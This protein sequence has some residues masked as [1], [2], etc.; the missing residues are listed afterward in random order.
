[1]TTTTPADAVLRAYA[2]AGQDHVFRFR[3]ALDA[4][5]WDAL[6]RQAARIDL[7]EVL[8]LHRTS[9]EPVAT[10]EVTAP[11]DEI[12][13][14]EDTDDH[15][16][17]RAAARARG[18]AEI[19]A[20]RV[21][22]VVA[23][24]GQGTRL[25]S[26]A[27]K[28]MWP[29]GPA[30]GK[31][32]LQWHAEKTLYWAR[33]TGR[34]VPFILMV[35]EATQDATLRF[36]RWH[37]YFGLD[38]TWVKLAC[39]GSLPSV[40]ADGKLLLAAKDCI[41][42]SPNGHGGLYR[43]LRDA[44]LLDLLDDFGVTTVSY[45]QVDNPLILPVDPVFLGYHVERESLISS[46]AVRKTDPSE[47]VGVFARVD[48]RSAILEYS[49]LTPEQASRT[50]AAGALTFG[51]GSIAAHCIDLA[52]ARRMADEGLPVHRAHKKVPYVDVNGALVRPATPNATKF[53]TFLFDAIPLAERS[54]VMETPRSAEFSPIKNA[55]G[56][57]SPAT[58]RAD[59]EALFRSWM[60]GVGET[61]PVGAV[62][63]PPAVAP[64]EYAYRALRGRT[65][66]R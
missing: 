46:K 47:K 16:R 9:E 31:S 26:P 54:L 17:L 34:A 25:G 35:S 10:R 13:R 8:A 52:F 43:A 3:D 50:D 40:D 65:G 12:I 20:G 22:V 1:M 62:E 39:Q 11:G 5:Q 19:A 4:R 38:P 56:S 24:G 14:I 57:D 44:K 21:A 64:D 37:D 7:D 2:E 45:V 61:V 66:D 36:L 60:E 42:V 30:S 49:E 27:P 48:G 51:M 33:K 59:M 28:G 6:V 29:C 41:A 15:R 18:E 23:A 63:V 58:A 55:T 53:E 32:L